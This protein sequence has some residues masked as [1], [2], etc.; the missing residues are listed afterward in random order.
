MNKIGS[1]VFAVLILLSSPAC[2]Q[3]PMDHLPDEPL[4]IPAA[5]AKRH[6]VTYSVELI[7]D[8][9]FDQFSGIA[10]QKVML[11]YIGEQLRQ[12]GAFKLVSYKPFSA[13]S[14]RHIHFTAHYSKPRKKD[15]VSIQALMFLSF[16]TIPT[17]ITSDLDMTAIV[18]LQDK[19]VYAPV[20]TVGLRNYVWLG[21]LP[22][23][24]VWNNWWA[25][26]VQEKKCSRRLINRIIQKQL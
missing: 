25:W 26:T 6:D 7:I 23:G 10:P 9:S 22:V 8:G 11:R 17:W 21:F 14:S 5:G 13:K 12:S 19:A 4:I 20:T 16:F 1:I 2:L 18:Y 15:V 3:V 24:L